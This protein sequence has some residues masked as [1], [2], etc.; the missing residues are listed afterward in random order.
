MTH[1]NK[2]LPGQKGKVLGFTNDGKISRRLI[3]LGLIPGR[4]VKYIRN[5]PLHDPMEIQ[6]GECC[7]SIRHAE[8]SLVAIELDE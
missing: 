2:M 5:A 4:A 1:L 3:E 8:A 6:V 7:L